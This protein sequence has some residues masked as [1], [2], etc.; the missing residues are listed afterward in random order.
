MVNGTRE[1]VNK[2]LRA[3]VEEGLLSYERG[4]LSIYDL[5]RLTEMADGGVR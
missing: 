2:Q 4:R 3:W 1:S 5:D